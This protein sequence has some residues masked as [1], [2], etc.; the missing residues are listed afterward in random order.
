MPTEESVM[1]YVL[2]T[3]AVW[4]NYQ[5]ICTLRNLKTSCKWILAL[6]KNLLFVKESEHWLDNDVEENGRG[7][8]R[9]TVT[10]FA[11]DWEK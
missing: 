6:F 2:A 9:A 3:T 10:K 11:S 7:L 4:R 5:I 1:L 8:I